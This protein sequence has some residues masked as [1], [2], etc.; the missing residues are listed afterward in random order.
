MESQNGSN[1][2]KQPNHNSYCKT[3]SEK[4]RSADNRGSEKQSTIDYF[5]QIRDDK[6]LISESSKKGTIGA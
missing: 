5:G 6:P 4:M 2:R 1:F 3:I